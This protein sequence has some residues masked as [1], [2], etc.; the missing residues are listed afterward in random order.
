MIPSATAA[1]Q[2]VTAATAASSTSTATAPIAALPT[3]SLAERALL[4]ALNIREWTG[5][6]RD[7]DVT[8]SV[9]R[10]HGADRTVG[11]YTKALVP[12]AFFASIVKVR[13]EARDTH[14]LL[15][16]P[17]CDDGYRILPA[18]LHLHYMGCFRDFRARFHDAVSGF[19]AAYDDAKAAARASLGSLYHDRDYPSSDRL[20]MA[21]ELEVKLQPLPDAGDFRLD[22]PAPTVERLRLDLAARLEDAQRLAMGDLYRRLAAVV[23][24]MA[25]TLAE[26]DRRFRNTLVG[27]VRELCQ[28]LPSLNIARDQ[29]L[30]VLAREIEQRL[31][32]LD[33]ALL[34]LDPATRQSAALD[35]AALLA[36]IEHR[37][38][39]YTSTAA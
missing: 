2:T 16:L 22:L 3:A 7:R 15:T 6:R 29:D 14:H 26:P 33:P 11:C 24:R 32:A 28:L 34:R 10:E 30:A 18:D 36:D 13:N 37:L 39:S 27:N 21:F 25:T 35:A 38:A 8:E 9:A 23:S 20:R 31:A 1:A 5:R 19:L 17:W 4:A 12:K